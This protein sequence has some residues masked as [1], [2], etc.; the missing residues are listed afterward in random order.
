MPSSSQTSLAGL[1]KRTPQSV[2]ALATLAVLAACEDKAD[3]SVRRDADV[4]VAAAPTGATV[5]S[6]KDGSSLDIPEGLPAFAPAYPG[7]TIKTQI[8]DGFG[9]SQDGK[10]LLLVMVSSDPVDKIA[11]FY[12]EKAKA[13]GVKPGMFVNDANSAVRIFGN[14]SDGGRGPEGALIA[15]TKSDEGPGSEIVITSGI[16]REQVETWEKDDWKDV[17]RPRAR[18]Q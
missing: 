14:A 13:A 11:A 4:T 5:T 10:G 9:P 8:S 17:P 15:I 18:L 7:A 3:V 1:R 16:A 2:L 6:A 12:D